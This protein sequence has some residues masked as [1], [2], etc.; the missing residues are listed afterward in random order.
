MY[1]AHDLTLNLL[2]AVLNL[3]NWECIW[4]DYNGIPQE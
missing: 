1:S 3:T 2:L 4:N